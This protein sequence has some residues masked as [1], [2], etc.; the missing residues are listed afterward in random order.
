[1]LQIGQLE[2]D[3]HQMAECCMKNWSKEKSVANTADHLLSRI[4]LSFLCRVSSEATS[5]PKENKAISAR[6]RQQMIQHSSRHSFFFDNREGMTKRC[7]HPLH[8]F[9]SLC[10]YIF[11]KITSISQSPNSFLFFDECPRLNEA[12]NRSSS[13]QQNKGV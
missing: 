6:I 13:A 9:I 2:K 12:L 3:Y 11:P 1:M 5:T 8:G 4:F 7:E 10:L